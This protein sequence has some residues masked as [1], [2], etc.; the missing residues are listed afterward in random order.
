MYNPRTDQDNLGTICTWHRRYNFTDENACTGGDLAR[1]TLTIKDHNGNTMFF[2]GNAYRM[3]DIV[4]KSG[5]MLPLYLY[6]HNVQH[7][8][9]ESFIG[10]APH[11]EWDSGRVGFIFASKAAIRK[12]Y[13]VK[14][15]TK[16]IRAKAE[17]ALEAEVEEYDNY[18]N[19]WD[20]DDDE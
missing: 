6:D 17:A 9:T 1:L 7:L 10:R 12:W 3:D 11:A 20:D 8:S 15:I 13:G 14:R 19:D 5:V 4:A 2:A 18:L 16:A